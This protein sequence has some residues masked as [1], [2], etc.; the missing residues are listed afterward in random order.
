MRI[1]SIRHADNMVNAIFMLLCIFSIVF[2]STAQEQAED[3]ITSEIQET[4]A[5]TEERQ[6]SESQDIETQLDALKTT[7]YCPCG[8]DRMTFE[9]CHCQTAEQFKKDFRKALTE[10]ET[11]EDIR[12]VYL[13]TYGP[14]Y[15]AVMKAVGWNI[16]AYTMPVVIL[17]AIGGVIYLVRR[18]SPYNRKTVSTPPDAQISDALQKKI[19]SEL[20]Q[21]KQHN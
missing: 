17:L 12:T 13:Q 7:L 10:G 11:V 15:S 16:L 6:T 9:I 18:Q 14:Q 21:Y 19:E 5:N 2:A 1:P 20:D 3:P 8:C 4:E